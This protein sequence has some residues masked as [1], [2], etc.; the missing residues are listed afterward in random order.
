MAN[1]GDLERVSRELADKGRLIEAG[2][3]GYRATVMSSAA[4]PIQLDECRLAF[5]A[6]AQHLFASLMTIMDHGEEPTDGDVNKLDLIDKELRK[7]GREVELRR[8]TSKG[9]A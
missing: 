9:S 5:M 8:A 4:P 7:F 3:V 2:W 1:R 6:G